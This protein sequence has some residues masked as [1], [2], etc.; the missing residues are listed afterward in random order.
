MEFRIL[1]PLEVRSEGRELSLGGAKQRALLA[2]LLLHKNEVVSIDRLVDE[3]WGD[4]PPATAFKVVHVYVSQLRKALRDRGGRG[5]EERVLVTRAPG[6]MLCVEPGQLDADRFEGLV[7][8]ARQELAAGKARPAAHMLLEALTLWRG[9]AL[10]DFALDAFAQNEIARLE[11]ARISAVEER[12]EAD[13]ALGRHDE[14]VGELE[15]LV[16]SHPL[17]ERLRGQLMLALYRSGRQAEALAVY[18]AARHLFIEE[19]GLEPGQALQHLEKAIL[20]QDRSLEPA[21]MSPD[22]AIAEL[23][24]GTVTFLFTDIEGSTRLLKQLG[25]RYGDVLA[26]HQRI[27]REAVKTREGREIDTQGDSFFFAFA[28][29]NAALGAAVAAQRNLKA[30]HWP[31]GGEVRVRMG[32]HTGEPIVGD[33]RYVGLGVHRAAR[34]GAAAHGGQVLLSSATRELVEDEVGGVAVCELGSYQLK[35]FDRP[36]QLYQLNIE[37]LQTGFPPLKAQKVAG[38]HPLRRRAIL[39]S[40]LTG[41]IAAAVAIPILALSRGGESIEAAAGNSVAFVDGGSNRLVGDVRVGATPTYA[42]VGE[43]A[44]WV[45][46]ADGDT[47]SKVDP[48]TRTVVQTIPVGSSPSG[49]TTGDGAVWVVN[50]LDGTV[51]RIDPATNTVVQTIDVGN[52]PVGIVYADTSIWVANT[53]DDTITRIDAGSGRPTK[54]LP[55]AATEI[56]FGGGTLWVSQRATSR[57]VRVDPKT[58]SVVQTIPVGNDPTGIAFGNGAAWVA[59][60]LDGTVS[61]IDPVTNSVTATIP[62]GNGPTSVAVDSRGVWVSNQFDG[63]LVTIDPRTNQVVRRISIGNRPQGVI[64]AGGSVLVSVRQPAA[65]HRG[66]LLTIRLDRDRPPDSIDTAVAYD[67]N[68]WPYLRM[69]GDGLV[70]FKQVGGL[71]GTQLVPDLAVSLPTP[72]EGGRTYTFRLRPGIRYSNVRLVK[73]SDF[74]ATFE[75]DFKIGMPVTYYDGIMGTARCKQT[76]KRCDLSRGIVVDDAKR[77]VTFHLIGAEPEFLYR[78]AIPFA[79]VLPAGTPPHDVGARGLPATGPYVIASYRPKRVLRFIRNKYFHEWSKAAQPDGYPDAIVIQIGGTVDQGIKDV[80][81][82]KA[83]LLSTF[84]TGTPSRSMLA[85]IKTRFASQ[86]HTNPSQ[87]V[88]SLFLNTRVAP[89]DRLDVRR[90]VSYAVDRAAAV[91]VQGGPDDAQATCQILPPHYPGY[92]PYCPYTAGSTTRG[93]WTAPD[94]AKARALVARSGTRGMRITVWDYAPVKGFGPLAVKLLRSLGYRVSLK[95]LGDTFFS[96]AYDPSTKAQIGFWAWATDYPV[97]STWFAPTLTCAALRSNARLNYNAPEFCDPRIDRE[98]NQALT[99]Q[100]TNPE[101][102]RRR[103]ERI[104]REI[105]DAAPLVPLVAWKV[106][107]VLSKRVGNYQYNGR[108]M[109]L[110]IDQL[111]V[112]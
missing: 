48:S 56:A 14:L 37:G 96:T 31:E 71:A 65:G 35:D 19:L 100:A 57:V 32:L 26:E 77:T 110:L 43:G 63:S 11:E 20:V 10:A 91:Q 30:H 104:D 93:T 97:A 18:Q 66:G 4:Q 107:D 89:F 102:A 52:F 64:I 13:L 3:L 74:R 83:D 75:R 38:P 59:N 46:N 103:W 95:T 111:W 16:A 34:I 81:E 45:T 50:S 36:E 80:I 98:I 22:L 72:T 62:T 82:G 86:V 55:V 58:G 79:Y 53:G 84:S 94:L 90:A 101:A 15:S 42:A 49:I 6:Y 51:S 41:V 23:P 68:S 69:T 17:R 7:D 70:A 8:Q 87:Q 21:P 76:P 33:E 106:I 108:G 85:G 60:S 2:V 67:T 12:I 73:A 78:L 24:Q 1:G 47:V 25:E 88:G 105:V 5:D 54:T 40:A 39:L 9:P 44:Y 28:R 99:E 61:R 29:A 92:R 109:G 112:R 27:L